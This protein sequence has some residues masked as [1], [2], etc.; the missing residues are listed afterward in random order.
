QDAEQLR[1]RF[2]ELRQHGEPFAR[3][4]FQI[5]TPDGWVRQLEVTVIPQFDGD[6]T[7]TGF[8]G[9]SRD[10]TTT[11][12][13]LEELRRNRA[14]L[15]EAQR[16]ARMGSW[17]LDLDNGELYWSDEI[18]RLFDIE[19]QRFGATYEA[20][21]E[22]I[23]PDDRERVNQAYIHSLKTREPYMIDHRLQMRD[24]SIKHVREQC[25]TYYDEQGTPLRSVGTVQDITHLVMAETQRRTSEARFRSLVEQSPLSIQLFAPDGQALMVNAAWRRLWSAAD[26]CI[27]DYNIL[28]DR[29]LVEKGA[30]PAILRGF[31]GETVALPP[32][33]YDP[34]LLP[35]RSEA[36]GSRDRWVAGFIYPIKDQD[37][38][39]TEV[40]LIH[41]DVS[42]RIQ[43]EQRLKHSES[44]LAEA[45]AI[46]HLGNWDL[47]LKNRRSIWSDEEYRLLGYQ[48]GSITPGI[49]SFLAAVHPEDRQR[50][51]RTM[52]EALEPLPGRNDRPYY[53]E[54][55]VLHPDGRVI[56]V[57]ENGRVLFDE[58]GRAIRKYGTT[59]DI[60]RRR[61][62]ERELEQHSRLLEQRVAE[63]TAALQ[64]S[65]KE[66]ESFSY[67]VSHDLRA[68][69]RAIDGFSQA[70]LEDYGEHLDETGRDYL[71]RVRRSSQ[72]M[73]SL[74]DDL[75]MLSRLSR[76]RMRWEPVDLG[77][78]SRRILGELQEA[79]PENRVTIRVEQGLETHGDPDLLTVAMNNL[80]D[81]AWKYSAGQRQP[82]IR[83]GQRRDGEDSV[84]FVSDN[85]AGFDMQYAGKL[86]GAFQRLHQSSEFPGAG[87][88][89][90][91][92]ARVIHRHGGR[93][94]ADAAPNRGAT[95]YFT[96]GQPQY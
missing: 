15:A 84:F 90:A 17:E 83:V 32:T 8:I 85:G 62:A 40:V 19:P 73:G 38:R 87:I 26:D 48:P 29:Q 25:V 95:F 42:D 78:L 89:L 47:D 37:D 57:V 49:E 68:P 63:R 74:I 11:K 70:L 6:G 75:L 13:A 3:Q 88:G 27:T 79:D 30:M 51:E 18:Y 54:H 28:Q 80:L 72:R 46:A 94:W 31:A 1:L 92:V 5:T 16:I 10:V 82:E 66:L 9:A 77:A 21:L 36:P 4:P 41:E 60:T 64:A 44:L 58:Q 67:A 76:R 12:I 2:D 22:T 20:F 23:H 86:F 24:G 55:R 50:V 71:N 61:Q 34:A 53:V 33:R 56:E 69:L 59:M 96:L 43:A 45:Q 81:N 91:T 65:N 14:R 35:W 93:V 52:Q 39:L 7:C